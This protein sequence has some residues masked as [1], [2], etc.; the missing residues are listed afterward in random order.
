MGNN[1]IC[2]DAQA[3]GV[4]T[5]SVTDEESKRLKRI[6]DALENL[7]SRSYTG[8]ATAWMVFIIFFFFCLNGCS[9]K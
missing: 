4:E 1:T 8:S 9:F 7:Q 6:E 2:V 5:E 3:A